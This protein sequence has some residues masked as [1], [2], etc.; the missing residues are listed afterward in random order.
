MALQANTFWEVRPTAGNDTNGGGFVPGSSG[1]DWSQQNSPQYALSNGV[2][3]GTTTIGT[4]S[5]ATDMV[6]NIVYVAGGT[7]SVTAAWYE[8]AS[9]IAGVSITVD[10]STGLSAGTGVTLNI[11]GALVTVSQAATNKVQGNTIYCAATG[12]YAPTATLNL[13]AGD[14]GTGNTKTTFIG[15]TSVRGDGGKF[16]WT[17]ATNSV[18]LVTFAAA[19]NFAFYNFSFTCTAGTKGNGFAAGTSG[20]SGNIQL[21]NCSFDGFNVAVFGPF[22]GSYSWI[23]LLMVGCV[24]KNSVSHGIN[25]GYG[26][27]ALGCYIHDNGGMGIKFD[28]NGDNQQSFAVSR[29]VI[30]NNTSVG[31]GY[32]SGTVGANSFG[33]IENCAFVSNGS[34]GINVQSGT[35]SG[36]YIMNCIF[37]SNTG[38]GVNSTSAMH[39][40]M[41]ANA[42]YNNS[43]GKYPTA[44]T[45]AIS[46]EE[47]V[48]TGHPFTSIGSDWSLNGTSGAGAACKAAAYPQTIPS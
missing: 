16:T 23:P 42:F 39:L 38:Y 33:S 10:R 22:V 6:G 43:S 37:D 21:F 9:A 7:G 12:P 27:V 40:F 2:T 41:L 1:T 31:I 20:P 36:L 28:N 30:Y 46:L 15:Y 35:A 5:A 11:G 45:T 24:V 34:D 14:G 13:A 44:I 17:T 18:D 32:D 26:L 19:A 4:T 3:N 47:V 8:I 29:C 48:L 25:N